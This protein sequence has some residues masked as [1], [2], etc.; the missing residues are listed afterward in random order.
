MNWEIN[1]RPSM[2]FIGLCIVLLALAVFIIGTSLSY[3]TGEVVE[4]MAA[5]SGKAIAGA[6]PPDSFASESGPFRPSPAMMP[7]AGAPREGGVPVGRA[8]PRPG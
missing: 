3:G 8:P 4:I 6:G 2:V 5:K 1:W 7:F